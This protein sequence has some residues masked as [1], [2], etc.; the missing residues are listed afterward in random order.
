MHTL[1]PRIETWIADQR[2]FALATVVAV[3]GSSPREVG[4]VMAIDPAGPDFIG[5]VSSGCLEVEVIEAA[6]E[7]IA[8][9]RLRTFHFGPEG[10]AIWSD[11]LTCGGE[12]TVR[13]EPWMGLIRPTQHQPVVNALRNWI[14]NDLPGVILSRDL[15]HIAVTAQA[16]TGTGSQWPERLLTRA[17]AMVADEATSAE[18]E[19]EG[20]TIFMRTIL[21]RPRLFIVGAGEVALKLVE[22]AAIAGW[23]SIVVDPRAVYARA[24]R[25]ER[26][27]DELMVE[28]PDSVTRGFDFGRRDAAVVLTHDPKI[29]DAAL[30]E[31]LRTK[32]GYIGALGSR[33]SHASRLERL[34]D[35]GLE[36]SQIQRIDGP[37][38]FHLG[39]ANAIHIAMGIFAG[40]L[41][42]RS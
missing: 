6:H 30:V 36:E 29:D 4:S 28:W 26:L 7:V 18:I 21:K 24:G 31:L 16:V 32:I 27:P 12:V 35:A 1:W 8:Q 41:K 19:E 11:G 34:R 2:P 42:G 20:A 25:F 15:E 3:N 10:S 39:A 33:K 40:V 5:S 9:K 38:G 13:L 22:L 23:K 14:Q 37:C 17:A